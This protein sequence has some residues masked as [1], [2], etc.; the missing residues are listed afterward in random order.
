MN[1]WEVM[2]YLRNVKIVTSMKLDSK[3]VQTCVVQDTAKISL[4]VYTTCYEE[5]KPYGT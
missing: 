5:I 1:K 4:Y 2:R 3:S